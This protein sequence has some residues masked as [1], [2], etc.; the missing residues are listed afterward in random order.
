MSKKD[1]RSIIER[2][3][4]AS[5]LTIDELLSFAETKIPPRGDDETEEQYIRRIKTFSDAKKKA[6]ESARSLYND[7]VEKPKEDKEEKPT[8]KSGQADYIPPEKRS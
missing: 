5:D 3:D 7:M 4:S 8:N 6:I 1:R 2:I